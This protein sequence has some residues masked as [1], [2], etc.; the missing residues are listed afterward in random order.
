MLRRTLFQSTAA[1]ALLASLRPRFSFAKGGDVIDDPLLA[2]WTGSYGGFPRFDKIKPADFKPAFTKAM[3]L[4][5]AEIAAIATA[6]DAATFKNTIEAFENA[7]RPF[8]RCQ[9]LFGVY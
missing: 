1:A 3:D 2:A 7:G 4:N 8:S 5:R 9:N 6:K